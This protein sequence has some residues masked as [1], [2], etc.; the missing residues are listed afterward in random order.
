MYISTLLFLKLS[1]PTYWVIHNG[2]STYT[3]GKRKTSQN[4]RIG[5]ESKKLTL[6]GGNDKSKEYG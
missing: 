6:T 1:S 5:M 3:A 4:E 2:I